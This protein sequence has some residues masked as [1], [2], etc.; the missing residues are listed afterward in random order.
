MKS[1]R[2]RR[3]DFA[4]VRRDNEELIE[5]IELNDNHQRVLRDYAHGRPVW[6]D[7]HTGTND[8]NSGGMLQ[9]WRVWPG[10]L[11]A[12]KPRTVGDRAESICADCAPRLCTRYSTIRHGENKNLPCAMRS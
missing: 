3:S 10:F 4:V 6:I 9:R 7:R 5:L 12:L 1:V 2:A 11:W 8:L